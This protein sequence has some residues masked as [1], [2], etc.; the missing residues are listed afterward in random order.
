VFE[1]LDRQPREL[2]QQEFDRVFAPRNPAGE[3]ESQATGEA[4]YYRITKI[5]MRLDDDAI[6]HVITIGET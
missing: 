3:M 1:V 6:S 5:P 2:L 4:R